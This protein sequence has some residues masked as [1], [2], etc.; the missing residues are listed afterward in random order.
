MIKLALAALV[1]VASL[2]ATPVP[3]RDVVSAPVTDV[4]PFSRVEVNGHADAEQ[5]RA[6]GRLLAEEHPLG[7]RRR[8][9]PELVGLCS[10]H[11][12]PVEFELPDIRGGHGDFGSHRWRG[13]RDGGQHGG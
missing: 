12:F 1:A 9:K 11:R 7:A 10:R 5:R 2:T 4:G 3:A 6:F 13:E 8:T